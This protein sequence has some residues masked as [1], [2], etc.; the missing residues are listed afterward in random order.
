M[1]S[2]SLS[3]PCD[4][5]VWEHVKTGTKRGLYYGMSSGIALGAFGAMFCPCPK[6]PVVIAFKEAARLTII[7]MSSGSLAGLFVGKVNG[8]QN[9]EKYIEIATIV[10]FV[11]MEIFTKKYSWIH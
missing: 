2:V 10:T 8:V 7:G 4:R 1:K 11:A 3:S 9:K 5:S 6:F